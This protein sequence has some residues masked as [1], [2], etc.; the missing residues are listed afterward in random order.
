VGQP[1][2][3]GI[4]FKEPLGQLKAIG[5]ISW[6]SYGPLGCYWQ[7]LVVGQFNVIGI[8]SLKSHWAKPMP[9]AALL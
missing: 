2:A 5:C 7:Y 6:G 1:H 8:T 3:I 9:S 4:T